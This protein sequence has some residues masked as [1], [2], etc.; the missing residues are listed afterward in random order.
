MIYCPLDFIK[1]HGIWIYL[2]ADATQASKTLFRGDL[3]WFENSFQTVNQFTIDGTTM[4][5]GCG[6][7]A[8]V[9]LIRDIFQGYGG[10]FCTP[11]RQ[12]EPLWFQNG[13]NTT[14]GVSGN[15]L[16]Q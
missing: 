2:W 6:F 11:Q 9:K 7:Q 1:T 16:F 12:V 13:V 8:F 4:G 5:L 15:T 10:H 14:Y 3:F